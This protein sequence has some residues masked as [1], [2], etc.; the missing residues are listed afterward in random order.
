MFAP[1]D[2]TLQ[3]FTVVDENRRVYQ[4]EKGPD[5]ALFAVEAI[6]SSRFST[7]AALDRTSRWPELS[8]DLERER[9]DQQADLERKVARLQ[10]Q[11]HASYQSMDTHLSGTADYLRRLQE[12]RFEC[13]E[14]DRGFQNAQADL[15]HKAQLLHECEALRKAESVRHEEEKAR[16]IASKNEEIVRYSEKVSKLM[17]DL[18]RERER[19]SA[20]VLDRKGG[21]LK[22][23]PSASLLEREKEVAA[24]KEKVHLLTL[25]LEDKD[26]RVNHLYVTNAKLVQE[27]SMHDVQVK[28]LEQDLRLSVAQCTALSKDLERCSTQLQDQ[29]FQLESQRAGATQQLKEAQEN[30]RTLQMRVDV[31]LGEVE[32]LHAFKLTLN[33]ENEALR[34]DLKSQEVQLLHAE[35]TVTTLTLQVQALAHDNERLKEAASVVDTLELEHVRGQLDSKRSECETYAKHLEALQGEFA[36]MRDILQE[37]QAEREQEQETHRVALYRFKQERESLQSELQNHSSRLLEET[38]RLRA[39]GDSLVQLQE[40]RQELLH[41]ISLLEQTVATH[42]QTA[43]RRCQAAADAAQRQADRSVA[44]LRVA[45]ERLQQMS[46]SLLLVERERDSARSKVEEQ[47]SEVERLCETVKQL[48]QEIQAQKHAAAELQLEAQNI[49][50]RSLAAL[51]E[52]QALAE[53]TIADLR[54]E[55]QGQQQQAMANLE[56][57]HRLDCRALDV[58]LQEALNK[59]RAASVELLETH[60]RLTIAEASLKQAEQRLEDALGQSQQ[61]AEVRVQKLE[62]SIRL[63]TAERDITLRDQEVTCV[64]LAASESKVRQLLQEVAALQGSCE[65]QIA[66]ASRLRRELLAAQGRIEELVGGEAALRAKVTALEDQARER[67]RTALQEVQV[68]RQQTDDLRRRTEDERRRQE[69]ALQAESLAWKADRQE[70]LQSQLTSAITRNTSLAQDLEQQTASHEVALNE[71]RQRCGALQDDVL[72]LKRAVAEKDNALLQGQTK[73]AAARQQVEGLTKRLEELTASHQQLQRDRSTTVEQLARQTAAQEAMHSEWE[74]RYQALEERLQDTHRSENRSRVELQEAMARMEAELSAA[75]RELL[76]ANGRLARQRMEMEAECSKLQTA[77]HELKEEH[78]ASTQ[79]VA[80]LKG[81]LADALQRCDTRQEQA[82]KLDADWAA[83]LSQAE[84]RFQA[85]VAHKVKATTFALDTEISALRQEKAEAALAASADKSREMARLAEE[86]NAHRMEVEK[87]QVELQEARK[88]LLEIREELTSIVAELSSGCGVTSTTSGPVGS[89]CA[90]RLQFTQL[91]QIIFQLS[92]DKDGVQRSLASQQAM[93]AAEQQRLEASQQE[94]KDRAQDME[95]STAG[96]T[97]QLREMQRQLQQAKEEVVAMERRYNELVASRKA[98]TS[99]DVLAVE[100]EVSAL[101]KAL[102]QVQER[103]ASREVEWKLLRDRLEGD[104]GP[105]NDRTSQESAGPERNQL[106]AFLVTVLDQL[107]AMVQVND[108][109]RYLSALKGV[110]GMEVDSLKWGAAGL[111]LPVLQRL[112]SQHLA[113]LSALLRLKDPSPVASLHGL[114]ICDGR[115]HRMMPLYTIAPQPPGV[116]PSLKCVVAHPGVKR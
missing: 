37:V 40:E 19:C 58:R 64:Q 41:T 36:R 50:R 30:Q 48:Q 67:Q 68:L 33:A 77:L 85:E 101:R 70:S 21:T 45:E 24:L 59:E 38:G 104:G 29:C 56:E 23:E 110:G 69:S 89:S 106:W 22:T 13:D 96:L 46:A 55:L 3:P 14:K 31:I 61:E 102:G 71:W 95:R 79:Q 98:G 76:A 65:G 84:G 116:D 105:N 42:E 97:S 43:T 39:S 63:L 108:N 112:F 81:S 44:E 4:V 115:E 27:N 75:K 10:D 12:L 49:R 15:S 62:A 26:T 78:T 73:E 20:L 82:Q 52:S 25:E 11:L 66:E 94:A 54:R 113:I 6:E 80:E 34:A 87:M 35:E 103:S 53:T 99:A 57:T 107:R 2:V 17:E 28:E 109:G 86:R 74:T 9:I 88:E 90:W 47:K 18:R 111:S 92:A 72:A 60:H 114:P 51:E 32:A 7:V 93:W 91:R 1:I 100:A 83:K 5:N 16:L 8:I